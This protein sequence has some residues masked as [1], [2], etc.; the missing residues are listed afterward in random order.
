MSLTRDTISNFIGGV[1]QQTDKLIYPNQSKELINQILDP[2]EGLKKR[3]PKYNISKVNESLNVYPYIH[4]VI[5]EDEEFQIIFTGEDVKV[6]DLNGNQKEIYIEQDAY[7]YITSSNPLKDL[8]AVT[9]AD[10]TFILNKTIKTS[11]K[12]DLYPNAY[13]SSALIFVKQ[14]D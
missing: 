7:T 1:S 3:P 14:G 4:T 12:S 10:Y 8:Y 13:G 5:K 9:I 6:Y 2:I 11:L